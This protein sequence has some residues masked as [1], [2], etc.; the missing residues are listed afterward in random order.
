MSIKNEYYKNLAN[1][2]LKGF[3][4][5]RAVLA[6]TDE[7]IMDFVEEAKKHGIALELNNSSLKP[8]SFRENAY[9]NALIYLKLCK[10][11]GVPVSL[12][13]DSHVCYDIGDFSYAQKA[14]E[15]A[16]FPEELIINTSVERFKAYLASRRNFL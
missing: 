12:G 6:E 11:Y 5:V 9:E 8:G 4:T 10:E 14:I 7:Y 16:G 13:T 15:E 2:V 1:T 3:E